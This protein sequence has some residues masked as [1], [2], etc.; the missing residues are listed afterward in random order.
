M[1]VYD[2]YGHIQFL[3]LIKHHYMKTFEG[4]EV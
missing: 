3:C 2:S 1:D 4:G